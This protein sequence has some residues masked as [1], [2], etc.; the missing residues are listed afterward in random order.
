MTS[1]DIRA[2]VDLGTNSVKVLIARVD[3]DRVDP[4]YER[5]EQTRLGRGLYESRRLSAEGIA[6]TAAVLADYR[7]RADGLGVG[8]FRVLATS[9]AR[10]AENSDALSK[11]VLQ[12]AG[13]SLEIIPGD[14]EA[15]LVYRGVCSQGDRTGR[16]TL[17]VDVGGGSTEFIVGDRIEPLAAASHAIGTVRMLAGR[18]WEDPPG[19]GALGE[20]L[21]DLRRLLAVEVAPW[22]RPALDQLA[23][24][25]VEVVGPGGTTTFLARIRH[26]KD[27]FDRALFES[28]RF[29]RPEL[30]DLTRRLWGMT[31]GQREQL[32]GLP[33]NRADVILPGSAIY[34]AI[35]EEFDIPHLRVS[36]RGLRFGAMLGG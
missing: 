19:D 3:G 8:R 34:L 30:E 1:P 11:A 5:S 28:T 10:E 36:T 25:P 12:A 32:K 18:R 22:L 4:L 26:E 20:M 21:A 6:A 16:S 24:R 14:R 9:A 31:Q 7:A 13:V 23:E 35:L 15:A 29:S 2:V 17:A 27:E 33:A